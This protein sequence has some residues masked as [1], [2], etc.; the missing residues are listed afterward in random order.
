M[1]DREE[2][3]LQYLPPVLWEGDQDFIERFLH[4]FEDIFSD[5]E[6]K[7]D[8]IP[9]LFNPWTTPSHFLP[10]LA[11]WMAL[12]LE[13]H[14]T[15]IQSR[16]FMRNIVSLYNQRGGQESL[17]KYLRIYVGSN[18]DIAELQQES[19][20]HEFKIIINFP[21]F[22]ILHRQKIVRRVRAILDREKPAHTYYNLHIESPTMQIGLHSTIGVDTILGNP[23]LDS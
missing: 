9:Q 13:P 6:K 20:P 18:V 5:I 23:E 19:S 21:S 16:A 10:W 22:D 7:V 4:I 12:E 1:S 11:S 15:E 17:E 2:S 3:Y 8:N 14:W